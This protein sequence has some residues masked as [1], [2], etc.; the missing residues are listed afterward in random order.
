M[1]YKVRIEPPQLDYMG[2]PIPNRFLYPVEFDDTG[3]EII[4][5]IETV[6]NDSRR[7]QKEVREEKRRADTR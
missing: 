6:K 3:Q 7:I 5:L 2:R 4:K 1:K